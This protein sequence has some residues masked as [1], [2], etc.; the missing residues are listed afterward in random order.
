[1][2]N[3]RISQTIDSQLSLLT[4]DKIQLKGPCKHKQKVSK[5]LNDRI[6]KKLKQVSGKK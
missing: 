3:T 2:K 1:M 4:H 5:V 6:L